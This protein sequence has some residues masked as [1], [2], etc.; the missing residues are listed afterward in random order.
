MLKQVIDTYKFQTKKYTVIIC[1]VTFIIILILCHVLR[2][3]K[4]MAKWFNSQHD[5]I[6]I[7]NCFKFLFIVLLTLLLSNL[8]WAHSSFLKENTSYGCQQNITDLNWVF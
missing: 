2:N 4:Q 5:N 1:N 7:T 8:N 6:F 3:L